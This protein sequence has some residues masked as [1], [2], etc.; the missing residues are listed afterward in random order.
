MHARIERGGSAVELQ[1]KL[2]A[3]KGCYRYFLF[4]GH[5]DAPLPP[6]QRRKVEGEG[7][8]EGVEAEGVE[9]VEGEGE[10]AGRW[11]TTLGFTDGTTGELTLASPDAIAKMLS[12]Q[13]LELVFLN[14]CCSEP[15]GRMLRERG[16]PHVVCWGSKALD[17]AARKLSSTFFGSLGG[18]RDQPSPLHAAFRAAT[19]AVM[20]VHG[21]WRDG[22][23][24]TM[25]ELRDPGGE[26][27]ESMRR[28][29]PPYPAG[30]PLLLSV[31]GDLRGGGS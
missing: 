22:V 13:G 25:F 17:A 3:G 26:S 21:R 19:S 7:E 5:G 12:E 27:P 1:E 10:E 2:I 30:V 15:L 18:G 16:V 11:A 8:G 31:D 9:A 4:C 20:L 23:N 6:R 24:A 14:G 28:R 29:G